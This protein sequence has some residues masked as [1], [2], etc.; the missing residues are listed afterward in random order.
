[1]RDRGTIEAI[2]EGELSDEQLLHEACETR[3]CPNWREEG[4]VVCATCL[5]GRGELMPPHLIVRKRKL[6]GRR[7]LRVISDGHGSERDAECPTCGRMS[8]VV[9]RPGKCQCNHCG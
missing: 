2:R 7:V 4:Y 8:M 1:M 3:F 9:V 6:D 5:H